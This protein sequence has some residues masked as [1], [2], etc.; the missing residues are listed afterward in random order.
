MKIKGE[1]TDGRV[2][3]D[4]KELFAGRSLDVLRHNPDGFMWGYEGSGPAQLAL[5]L[6]LLV[7][8]NKTALEHYQEFKREFVSKWKDDFEVEVDIIA[9]LDKRCPVKTFYVTFGQ[10]HVHKINGKTF[11]KDCVARIKARDMGEAHDMAMALFNGV[12]CFVNEEPHL[13][14]YPRGIIDAA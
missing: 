5:A 4:G 9:W 10:V 14:F 2:W 7:T 1:I 3:V 6:L 12:F 8:G 11:D 13:E